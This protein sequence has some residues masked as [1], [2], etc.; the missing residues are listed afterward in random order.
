MWSSV[1]KWD[2]SHGNSVIVST[3][4]AD[5][6]YETCE[7]WSQNTPIYSGGNEGEWEE[8]SAKKF[9]EGRVR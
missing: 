8:D 1:P 7:D 2:L 6:E 5:P 9:D 3:V 4:S